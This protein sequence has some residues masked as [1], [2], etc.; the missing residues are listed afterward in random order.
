MS[1][2][3]QSRV[4]TLYFLIRGKKTVYLVALSQSPQSRVITLYGMNF[5]NG[6]WAIKQTECLNPL[7]V[8]SSLFT[9]YYHVRSRSG[10]VKCLNPLKVGSSLFTLSGHSRQRDTRHNLV[11]IPSKSG[12]HS[13][14][15]ISD[16]KVMVELLLSQSPQSRVITLYIVNKIAVVFK[17]KGV[18]SI[19]SKSGHHSLQNKIKKGGERR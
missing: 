9:R 13:L 11:S 16:Q 6:Q 1:Q 17:I 8:G 5:T 10:K 2:S 14:L 4:I 3:P 7:K 19:P 15:W 18:V 12:H